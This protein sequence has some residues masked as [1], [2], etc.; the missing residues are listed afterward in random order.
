[1][2][3]QETAK[4]YDRF[5]ALN[6]ILAA[7]IARKLDAL[8]TFANPPATFSSASGGFVIPLTSAD[9]A[10]L[11]ATGIYS[12]LISVDHPVFSN[13]AQVLADQ[14]SLTFVAAD[15]SAISPLRLNLEHSGYHKFRDINGKIYE[16]LTPPRTVVGIPAARFRQPPDFQGLIPVSI[17]GIRR[18]QLTLE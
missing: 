14:V 8:Q 15:G 16:F 11:A 1:L 4:Q 18:Q 12:F 5:D 13:L 6:S 17:R 7:L 3:P 10:A 9:R 2:N